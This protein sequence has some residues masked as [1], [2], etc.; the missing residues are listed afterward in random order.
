M[1]TCWDS[2]LCFCG[3]INLFV[4]YDLDAYTLH[5]VHEQDSV[6]A[7]YEWKTTSMLLLECYIARNV[8]CTYIASLLLE[9]ILRNLFSDSQISV[10][11]KLSCIV[12]VWIWKE[13]KLS[14]LVSVFC[15]FISFAICILKYLLPL[16]R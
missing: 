9:S 14:C 11:L 2:I 3:Y 13:T 12:E 1:H 6:V 8:I 16:K 5:A 15:S 7:R 10:K 4:V